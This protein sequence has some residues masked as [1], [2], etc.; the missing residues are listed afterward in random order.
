MK[1]EKAR[2]NPNAVNNRAPRALPKVDM[3]KDRR[4]THAGKGMAKP[5][6]STMGFVGKRIK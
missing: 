2:L 4:A 6:P 1:L 3:M 5:I